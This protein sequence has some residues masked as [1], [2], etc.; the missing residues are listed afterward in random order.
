M[1]GPNVFHH[2]FN[3]LEA[4]NLLDFADQFYCATAPRERNEV[5]LGQLEGLASPPPFMCLFTTADLVSEVFSSTEKF[6]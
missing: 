3:I 1:A 4:Q 5:P 2:V 6:F